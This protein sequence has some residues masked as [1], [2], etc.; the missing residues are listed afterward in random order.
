MTGRSYLRYGFIALTLL[1]ALLLACGEHVADP[2]QGGSG[3]G[4]LE[5]P[6][7]F[8]FS[9]TQDVDIS[10]RTLAP[11]NAPLSGIR[12]D[13]YAS[14]PDAQG[15]TGAI[16][17]TGATNTSGLLEST[18]N[19]A[20]TFDSVY[21]EA[22]SAGFV[23][24]V[25]LPIE[26]GA[27]SHVFGGQQPL[28][29]SFNGVTI[30]P[31]SLNKARD[32]IFIGSWDNQGVPNY[33]TSERD[34]IDSDFL[35]DINASL[36]ERKPVPQYNPEYI[37]EGTESN[38]VTLDSVD[39]WITFV[40]EGAGYRNGIGFYTYDVG[41]PPENVE[42]IDSLM[43]AFPN[44][45]YYRGGGGLYSGD[46]VYLG[47]FPG[48]KEIG[49]FIVA[50]G[51]NRRSKTLGNG[52]AIYFSD[53]DLN[54][55]SD[56]AKRPHNVLLYDELR[57]LFLIGFEDL[58]RNGGDND[59]ND[60]I[61]YV[62]A[63]PIENVSTEGLPPVNTPE[64]TDGDGVENSQDDYP[65]DPNKAFDV[66]SIPGTVAFD[67]EWPTAGD[68]DYN[69]LILDHAFT[70]VTDADNRVKAMKADFTIRAMGTEKRN[71][72]GFQLP[73]GSDAVATVTGTE[74]TSGY[75]NTDA[76]GLESGQSLPTI[77][78][79]DDG[80]DLVQPYQSGDFIN[81]QAGVQP[82][83]NYNISI[84]VEFNWTQAYSDLGDPPYNAFLIIDGERGKEVHAKGEQPTDLVDVS[85]LGT[86]DDKSNVNSGK[87]Y[88]M[89]NNLSWSFDIPDF[90]DYPFEGVDVDLAYHY[91]NPWINSSGTAHKDWYTKGSGYREETN[92]YYPF[93]QGKK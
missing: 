49:W 76:K 72:F 48:N 71:G 83:D 28:K 38:V 19:I 92:I 4:D 34:E 52:N 68:F 57:E 18:I 2:S 40:H 37:A 13:F 90:W 7:D 25:M 53:P 1:L 46:K 6:D 26:S 32:Y 73:I 66:A 93:G 31:T 23:N 24:Q 3:S 29:N 51:W 89:R 60:A 84:N 62:S 47:K 45:S 54:P 5:A 79:F 65:L 17:F 43:V 67:D 70:M 8:D 41:N 86:E 22:Q 63:T 56:P 81:T 42:D 33:L 69:D 36:P 14:K 44:F 74:L 27:L 58:N 39:I 82:V 55:E 61:F 12:I 9:T 77:I 87:Y 91:W 15:N 75:I 10:I 78:V 35:R 80:Y 88:Y 11:D 21:V 30:E 85:Y 20:N 16:I 59:F 50:N 64:D